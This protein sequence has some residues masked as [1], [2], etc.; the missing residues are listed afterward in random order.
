MFYE[1]VKTQMG[2]SF[3]QL[4]QAYGHKLSDSHRIWH[5]KN[6]AVLASLRKKPLNLQVG[7]VVLIPIPWHVTKKNLGSTARG[8]YMTA[9]R[10]GELG[11]RLGWVQT[12][13][14]HNQ[15]VLGTAPHCVDGCPADDNLPFYW[16]ATEIAASPNRRKYFEDYS[17]RSVPSAA[18]GTTRW[19]AILSLAVV[20]QQRV[21][22]WDSLVWGWNMTPANLITIIGPRPASPHESDGHRNLLRTGRGTGPLA[23]GKAGW[24]FRG[25]P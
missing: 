16:T 8:A 3:D 10:D 15:P 23:F 21:T 5:N 1:N 7:D 14:Q 11:E 19:R 12:V 18:Q 4:I 13:Y 22:V 2:E 20:T 17:Q 25:A 6:N 24:V 9:E